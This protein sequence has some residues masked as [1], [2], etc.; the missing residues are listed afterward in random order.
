MGT[1][2]SIT[3]SIST[4]GS[5]SAAALVASR[6]PA[7]SA[8][9]ATAIRPPR[10]TWERLTATTPDARF[11]LM[12]IALPSSSEPAWTAES[13]PEANRP[14]PARRLSRS[15][16]GAC[17]A[18]SRAARSPGGRARPTADEGTDGDMADLHAFGRDRGMQRMGPVTKPGHRGSDRAASRNR[19]DRR[20]AGREQNRPRMPRKHI[21]QH[22]VHGGDGAVNVQVDPDPD[23]LTG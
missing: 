19:K 7:D 9:I 16:G 1:S 5:G 23:V 18:P 3:G 15:R 11:V 14:R 21:G 8:A 2:C 12:L 13:A 10:R 22:L 6:Q 20:G 4:T 17:G